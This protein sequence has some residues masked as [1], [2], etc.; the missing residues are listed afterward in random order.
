ML[1]YPTWVK[2]D[3]VHMGPLRVRWYGLMYLVG[4]LIGRVLARRLCKRGFLRLNP[5]L[6]DDFLVSL[7]AGMVIGARIVYMLV[8]YRATPDDPF[9]WWT[10]FAVWQGGLAFH[11]AVIGMV[12]AIVWFARYHKLRMWNLTDVLALAGSQG[13]IF[14]RLGNFINAELP[15]RP[16]NGA[17]GM[18]FPIRDYDGVVRD[19][20]EPRHPSQLYE[21]VG[22]GLIPFVLIWLLKPYM[23]YEGVLGGLW[24]CFYA[25]AR[26][27]IEFFREKDAQLSYYFGWMT[28]GQILCALMFLIGLGVVFYC[29]W[30]AVPITGPV[31]ETAVEET[32][33]GQAAES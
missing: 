21:A 8:Y 11:G 26:F 30:R 31:E 14:G 4:F 3:L 1:T 24:L 22:E 23:K 10:P 28:M 33:G 17:M 2:P 27:C 18:Q 12:L 32:V 20:T 19:Y 7:F 29:Q 25:I 9:K 6:I 13:I 16:T 15:G 5:D